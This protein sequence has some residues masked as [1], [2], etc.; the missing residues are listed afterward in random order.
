MRIIHIVQS[1]STD[2]LIQTAAAARA[3]LVARGWTQ[4][5]LAQELS[6]DQPWVSNLVRGK[7][8][9]VND[10]VRAAHDYVV[11]AFSTDD[12]PQSC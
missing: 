10:R 6:V 9:E 8:K 12:I 4:T 2:L 11:H 1:T 3:L 7:L 5:Q